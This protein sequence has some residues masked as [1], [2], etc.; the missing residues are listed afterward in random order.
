MA[1]ASF[2]MWD[3]VCLVFFRSFWAHCSFGACSGVASRW[4]EGSALLLPPVLGAGVWADHA[5]LCQHRSYCVFFGV[6]RERVPG[7]AFFI[8]GNNQIS[9]PKEFTIPSP[10][11]NLAVNI[12]QHLHMCRNGVKWIWDLWGKEEWVP[13][14]S[15]RREGRA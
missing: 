2:K 12:C 3:I 1:S 7:R 4:R 13:L 14:V 11:I 15:H 10:K 6:S 8:M 9:Q 5:L